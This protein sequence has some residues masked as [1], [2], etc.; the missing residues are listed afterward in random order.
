MRDET[1]NTS[2]DALYGSIFG[3]VSVGQQC[4]KISNC[5]VRVLPDHVNFVTR[6]PDLDDWFLTI[7]I[8]GLSDIA[9][10]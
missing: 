6:V 3:L 4:A 9:Q 1:N 5:E 8:C 7:A 10:V 2:C